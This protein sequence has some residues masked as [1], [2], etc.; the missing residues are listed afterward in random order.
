M[1]TVQ[2]IIPILLT[3]L[4]ATA[5]DAMEEPPEDGA[6]YDVDE[7]FEDDE[8][9]TASGDDAHRIGGLGDCYIGSPSYPGCVEPSGPTI[10]GPSC[11]GHP[12]CY[13]L[14]RVDHQ[15]WNDPSECDDLGEC[16]SECD[17]EAPNW[18]PYPGTSRPESVLECF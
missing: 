5:C 6:G 16:L 14:C 8:D 17:E 10:P 7:D 12:I 1:R 3:A 2:R 18:C 9:E 13:C 11:A 4:L 15:C